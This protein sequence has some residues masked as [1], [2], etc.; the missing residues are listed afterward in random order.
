M[1][2][3]VWEWCLNKFQNPKDLSATAVD[4][5][6]AD[7]ALR[8][9]FFYDGARK[10]RSMDRIGVSPDSRSNGIGFRVIQDTS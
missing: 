5:S 3:N 1:L 9:G 8:G 4:R 10:C 7:R 6:D 2:G